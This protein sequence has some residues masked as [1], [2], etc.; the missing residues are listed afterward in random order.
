MFVDSCQ[1]CCLNA[2][3]CVLVRITRWRHIIV[4]V[5]SRSIVSASW[6]WVGMRWTLGIRLLTQRSMLGCP[7]FTFVNTASSIWRRR[8]YPDVMRYLTFTNLLL[9]CC[10]C[11][12]VVC[13]RCFDHCLGIIQLVV[14]TSLF[15]KL[16][17]AVNV[18]CSIYFIFFAC[19]DSLVG[20][21]P[22][23]MQASIFGACSKPG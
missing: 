5:T 1:A 10:H 11:D 23:G 14:F 21:K 13:F 20:T 8:W 4:W 6:R 16:N 3:N 22:P 19:A 12:F 9:V 18:C 17:A 7:R 2:A 15:S